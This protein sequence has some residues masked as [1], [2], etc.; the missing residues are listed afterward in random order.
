MPQTFP[1]NSCALQ[2]SECLAAC[3]RSCA[4]TPHVAS[5]QGVGHL[6][7][8]NLG[9]QRPHEIKIQAQIVGGRQQCQHAQDCLAAVDC[10]AL[11]PVL[12][13]LAACF[14]H[15]SSLREVLSLLHGVQNARDA[16]ESS[17]VHGIAYSVTSRL[18][19]VCIR[20]FRMSFPG[21]RGQS[22]SHYCGPQTCQGS[23]VR[24]WTSSHQ[25]QRLCC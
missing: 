15:G 10:C 22:P 7:Q 1:R 5:W 14:A 24:H 17:S 16:V 2:G 6:V 23:C 21:C 25:L 4:S 13:C 12:V 20:L 19:E 8:N 3:R 11:L 18:L 9:T